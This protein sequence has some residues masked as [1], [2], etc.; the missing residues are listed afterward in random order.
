MRLVERNVL[1]CHTCV[2]AL[3]ILP[4][5]IEYATIDYVGLYHVGA[6]DYPVNGFYWTLGMNVP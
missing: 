5:C 3:A 2:R 6:E 1:H 4:H